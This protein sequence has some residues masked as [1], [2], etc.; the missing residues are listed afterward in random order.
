MLLYVLINVLYGNIS[1]FRTLFSETY[2]GISTH[3]EICAK[4]PANIVRDPTLIA[5]GFSLDLCSEWSPESY[6]K[7]QEKS[8]L[9]NVNYFHKLKM[10]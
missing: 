3:R 8:R 4:S 6:A 7:S 1:H 2:L 9:V 10:V 5:T